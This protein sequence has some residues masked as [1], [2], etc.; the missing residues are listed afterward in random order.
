[1]TWRRSAET[2]AIAPH[3]G[4]L[5]VRTTLYFFVKLSLIGIILFLT[6]RCSGDLDRKLFI[7]S[8]LD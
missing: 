3:N 2:L 6:V 7:V 4:W 1:M 8:W 5:S